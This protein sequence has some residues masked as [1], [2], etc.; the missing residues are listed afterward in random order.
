MKN[1]ALG[2]LV[3]ALSSSLAGRAALAQE[4]TAVL[5]AADRLLDSLFAVRE[6]KEVAVSPDGRWAAW[7]EAIPP[8]EN[9]AARH[10]AIYLADLDKPDAKPRRLTAGDAQADHDEHGIAWSRDGGR[11]AFLSDREQPGQLQVYLAEPTAGGV[12]RVTQATG[13]LADPRFSPDG[14]RLALLLTAGARQAI[15]A[16][17]PAAREVGVVEEHVDE[18]RLAVVELDSGEMR[19]VSPADHHVYEYDWSPDGERFA[20]IAAPGSGD[21]NWYIAK[22]YSV[23]RA[24]GRMQA[25]FDPGMQIAVPRWSPDG[26]TI[27]FVG[28]LMSD[29]GLNGGD[30]FLAPAEGGPPRNVTPE[31][32]ASASWLSWS[33]SSQELMFAEHV[34]GGS[35]LASLDLRSGEVDTLW[36][37]PETITATARGFGV[38]PGISLSQDGRRSAVIRHSFRQPPEIWVG[39]I[40]NWK[41]LTQ[42]NAKRRPEWGEAKSLH[43]NNDGRDVQGWLMYPKDYDAG[44][45]Y[46]MVV[47]VH[48]GPA[49]ACK[50]HW[51][52]YSD[53]TWLSGLGYFVFCPNPRGSLGQGT[54]FTRANVKDF[55]HGD[56]SDILSG[57]DE[58]V[59]TLPV[60]GDRL[61][62][63]GWSYGGYMT[64]WAVTQTNRFRAAIAG[65]GIANWQS[66]Y[67]Q[68]EIDQWMIPFFGASVYDDPRV[69]AKSSPIE[70]IKQAA[71]PTLLLVGERDKECPAAQS[72][73]FWHALKT[74]GVPTQLVIYPGEGHSIAQ[75]EHRRD[76]A[77]RSVAWFHE[78][79]ASPKESR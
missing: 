23:E 61:G 9:V 5:A 32:K 12:R 38:T 21:N 36:T 28:G 42:A 51:P 56:L 74:L 4:R 73:E 16:T 45:R 75:L 24:S 46:P 63:A 57:V 48:G 13:Y 72:R 58:I 41:Q 49:S 20:V 6:L 52:R 47:S 14:Q 44:R 78:R 39:P 71:T 19:S 69:Y 25:L 15:G 27:A 8:Q 76:I 35:G 11:L 43:W 50:P 10:S 37:G 59:G 66:Y 7:V 3:L 79:V 68:N 77:R 40:G 17:Q 33:A 60:D 1:A 53:L 22:L 26:R 34:D 65:A 54:A 29:E 30:I 31:R 18:Q 64:M 2:L 70:F 67:G 55:G 62:I